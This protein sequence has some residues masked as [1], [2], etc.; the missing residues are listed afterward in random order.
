MSLDDVV[1]SFLS[2]SDGFSQLGDGNIDA[3]FF[4]E[5]YQNILIFTGLNLGI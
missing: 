1:P 3:A 2:Y 4:L 5:V